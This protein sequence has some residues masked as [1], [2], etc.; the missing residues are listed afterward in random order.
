MSLVILDLAGN[1]PRFF[2]L[3]HPSVI[4]TSTILKISPPEHLLLQHE[5]SE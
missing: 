4:S 3:M 5:N 1:F 2:F